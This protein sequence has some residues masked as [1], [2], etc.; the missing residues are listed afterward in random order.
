MLLESV[1]NH[2]V[3]RISSVSKITIFILLSF[4]LLLFLEKL[5]D[6]TGKKSN[7]YFQSGQILSKQFSEG[8]YKKCNLIVYFHEEACKVRKIWNR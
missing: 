4:F 3:D 1:F 6:L 7:K 8:V 2:I 5:D